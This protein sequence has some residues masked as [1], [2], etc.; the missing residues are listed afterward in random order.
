MVTPD[1]SQP[2]D[3]SGLVDTQE[4]GRN[5]LFY[6]VIVVFILVIVGY[7][8]MPSPEKEIELEA[9]QSH[10]E[11]DPVIRAQ[12]DAAQ[13][14]SNSGSGVEPIN[15]EQSVT[16]TEAPS[17]PPESAEVVPE[18]A[19]PGQAAQ[20]AGEAARALIASFRQGDKNLTL[21]QL[22]AQASD[23]QRQGMSTDAFLLYFF[24]ARKGYGPSAFELAKMHDPAHFTSGSD[25]LDEPDPVQAYKWYSIAA[26]S[27]VTGAAEA[28]QALR[29]S[30][31]AAAKE[32][33]MSAQ[34][35][36]LNWK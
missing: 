25:L 10:A 8:S 29:S 27:G 36:L 23:Y 21:E 28:L 6:I 34:R 30:I 33:D 26:E 20:H 1:S 12:I 31:E 9:P 16:P 2:E 19:A 3:Y 7:F 17:P 11:I 5:Y 24:A 18:T 22:H 14:G 15:R 32:G 4:K 13:P 35:L